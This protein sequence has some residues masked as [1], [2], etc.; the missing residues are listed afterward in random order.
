MHETVRRNGRRKPRMYTEAWFNE[1]RQN[2]RVAAGKHDMGRYRRLSVVLHTSTVVAW[3]VEGA[4][5]LAESVDRR[6]GAKLRYL[7]SIIAV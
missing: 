6:F 3:A 7:P 4:A 5:I 1:I 2:R